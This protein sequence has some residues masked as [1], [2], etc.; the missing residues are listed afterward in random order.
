MWY[1]TAAFS[2]GW[3]VKV[4]KEENRYFPKGGL[5]Q[6]NVQM[7]KTEDTYTEQRK[8]FLPEFHGGDMWEGR[9]CT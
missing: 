3:K 1:L 5:T 8:S 4:Y 2:D 9:A 7:W 6:S